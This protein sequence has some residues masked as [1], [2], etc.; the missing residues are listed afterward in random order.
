MGLTI[1]YSGNFGDPA[2]LPEMISEVKDIS[3]EFKWDYHIYETKFPPDGFGQ[4]DYND[5]IYGISTAPPNCEPLWF[6]FLSNGK[7]SSPPHLQF[8]GKTD[9][10]PED[11]FLYQLFTKTQFAGIEVHKVVVH[12]FRHISEKYLK[13]FTMMD[14]GGYWE[15]RDEKVL[16]QNFKRY[17]YLIDSFSFALEN[18]PKNAGENLEEYLN[19]LFVKIHKGMKDM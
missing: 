1:H 10:K 7:M 12:L 5:N 15:S 9:T 19:R 16:E 8:W 18:F 11:E 2:L 17:N 14:E 6:C 4:A 3:G 13:D